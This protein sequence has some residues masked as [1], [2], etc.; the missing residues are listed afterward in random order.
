M[1]FAQFTNFITV[2]AAAFT[3]MLWLPV[4]V[5]V[6]VSVAVIDCDPDVF[7]VALKVP[8]PPVRVVFAGSPLPAVAFESG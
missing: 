4:I 1:K 7:S 3:V 8:A 6:T 5:P 2:A